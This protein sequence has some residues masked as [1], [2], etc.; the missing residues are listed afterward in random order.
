MPGGD[1]KFRAIQ[2]NDE[3]HAM[4]LELGGVRWLRSV[5]RKEIQ[6]RKNKETET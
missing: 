6:K 3:D 1:V 4:F 5:L 2:L